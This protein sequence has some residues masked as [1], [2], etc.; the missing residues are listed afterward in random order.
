MNEGELDNILLRTISED[1]DR[2]WDVGDKG[3]DLIAG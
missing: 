1:K 2:L 3:L